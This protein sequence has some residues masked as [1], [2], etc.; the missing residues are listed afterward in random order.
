M[1]RKKGAPVNYEPTKI[2]Q[3]Y[4]VGRRNDEEAHMTRFETRYIPL[5]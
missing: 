4:Q 5:E 3:G 1:W 2:R